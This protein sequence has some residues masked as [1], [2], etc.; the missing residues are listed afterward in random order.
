MA[1]NIVLKTNKTVTRA[2]ER[3]KAKLNYN[4]G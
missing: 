2:I 1:Y 3:H 4:A